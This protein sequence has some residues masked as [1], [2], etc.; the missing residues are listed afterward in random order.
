MQKGSLVP[1]MAKMSKPQTFSF[2]GW[3]QHLSKKE[4]YSDIPWA[5]K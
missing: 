3:F 1:F 4:T 5:R 2:K